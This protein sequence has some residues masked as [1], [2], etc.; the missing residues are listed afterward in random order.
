MGLLRQVS[1]LFVLSLCSF[2]SLVEAHRCFVCIPSVKK[3]DN[4]VLGL[5]NEFSGDTIQKCEDF[6]ESDREGFIKECPE[7]SIGCLTQF[8]DRTFLRS[9]ARVGIDICEEANNVTYCYC[10]SNECNTPEPRLVDPPSYIS[11]N[12]E[13]FEDDE[14]S[15][16][17]SG[18]SESSGQEY[19]SLDED[20]TEFPPVI[21]LEGNNDSFFSSG[22]E[23][24]VVFSDDFEEIEENTI[25]VVAEGKPTKKKKKNSPSSSSQGL[26]FW[27]SILI[28]A[29]SAHYFFLKGY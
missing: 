20:I 17:A 10:S 7:D 2:V 22:V 19:N 6:R 8:Q 5:I 21:I 9:C 24:E 1:L 14:D 25:R 12:N 29:L 13:L 3:N 16:E 23:D 4:E 28:G 15:Y 26:C 27:P 18:G 11:H